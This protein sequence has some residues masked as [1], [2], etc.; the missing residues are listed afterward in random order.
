MSDTDAK[1]VYVDRVLLL[2][3]ASQTKGNLKFSKAF[4]QA[5]SQGNQDLWRSIHIKSLEVPLLEEKKRPPTRHPRDLDAHFWSIWSALDAARSQ[6]TTQAKI[7]FSSPK[8]ATQ[9]LVILVASFGEYNRLAFL[10]CGHRA[11]ATVPSH[12]DIMDLIANT[13]KGVNP[14]EV[15]IALRAELVVSGRTLAEL[16]KQRLVAMRKAERDGDAKRRS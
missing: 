13:T 9:N 16:E 10:S 8:F 14:T 11:L 15:P 4:S 1:G 3:H 7:L 6:V 12:D 5:H 2:P